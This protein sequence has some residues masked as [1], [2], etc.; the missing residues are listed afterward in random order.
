MTDQMISR[1]TLL[2]MLVELALLLR[3]AIRSL[4]AC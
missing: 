4:V 1:D 3:D 2:L